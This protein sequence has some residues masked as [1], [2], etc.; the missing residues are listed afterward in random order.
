MKILFLEPFYTGSHRYF[1]EGLQ[2]ESSHEITIVSLP[3][4]FWKWRMRGASLEFI[5]KG[6]SLQQYDLV[7]AGN[8]MD[9]AVWKALQPSYPIPLILYVHENQL[10]YPVKE[11]EIRDFQYG[12]TD[13]T[14]LLCAD[15]IIYNSLFNKA[16]FFGELKTLISRL[17]DC[18]P[19][20]DFADLKK[21]ISII[22]PGCSLAET[23]RKEEK[24]ENTDRQPLILWN[25][26][27]EHDKNPEEFFSLLRKLKKKRVPFRLALLG[28]SYSNTPPCFSRAAEEFKDELVQY[29][30]LEDKEI[31]RSWLNKADF[32]LSTSLQENFGISI[33]EAVSYGAIPLLPDRL[34]YPEVLPECFH[35]DLL[36]RSRE[37]FFQKWN[38]LTRRNDLPVL[39][40]K[41]ADAMEPYSWQNISA[42]FDTIFKETAKNHGT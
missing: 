21:R 25:H 18:R 29:G 26:R 20:T 12:W 17:P 3:G 31:Y 23:F 22:P 39:R 4:R 9:L 8:L 2:K 28:E 40:K 15:T 41:L 16:S 32:V 14:N 1:A 35:Q 24:F 6:I 34:A 30:Y 42:R 33:V 5:R 37:D 10:A 38:T 27:W 13:Y 19:D 7:L 11:G 36:Y